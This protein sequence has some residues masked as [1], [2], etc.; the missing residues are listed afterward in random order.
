MSDEWKFFM[1]TMGENLASIMVN[2][3]ISES[4]A[5]TPPNLATVTL[6]YKQPD[7]RGMPTNAEFDAVVALEDRLDAFVK[8]DEDA[9]VGRITKEGQRIFFVYTH[10]GKVGALF[11]FQNIITNSFLRSIKHMKT[12]AQF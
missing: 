2:V 11:V 5:K 4:I 8:L 6:T 12:I 7:E 1:C 9:Y 3:G 10:K